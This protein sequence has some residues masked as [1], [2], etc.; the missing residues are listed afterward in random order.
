MKNKLYVNIGL[1]NQLQKIFVSDLSFGGN[2]FSAR[3]VCFN[4]SLGCTEM[5]AKISDGLLKNGQ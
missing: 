5:C 3:W 4:C 1:K 2:F